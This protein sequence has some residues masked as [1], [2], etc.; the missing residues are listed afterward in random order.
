MSERQKKTP[1][2]MIERLALGELDAE[3]ANAVRAQLAAEGRSPDEVLAALGTS[4]REILAA[5]PAP[6]VAAEVR[7]RAKSGSRWAWLVGAPLAV[8]GVAAVVLTVVF[9]GPLPTP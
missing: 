3:T 1:D 4:N 8:V 5:H 6:A 9:P 2:W 7:R